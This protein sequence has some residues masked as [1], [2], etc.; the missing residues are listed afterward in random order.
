[1]VYRALA[2]PRWHSLILHVFVGPIGKAPSDHQ[3]IFDQ[4][5]N[6]RFDTTLLQPD[7]RSSSARHGC[8]NV[9]YFSTRGTL[10]EKGPCLIRTLSKARVH[11]FHSNPSQ[12]GALWSKEHK[13]YATDTVTL[14]EALLQF[15]RV[16]LLRNTN[17]DSMTNVEKIIY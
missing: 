17:T 15:V 14:L 5:S 6:E 10:F 8:S 3:S 7:N 4:K 1:M 13:I 16:I 9:L 2:I 11:S 12:S